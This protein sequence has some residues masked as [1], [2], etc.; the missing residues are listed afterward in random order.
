MRYNIA[1]RV[2]VP[3]G[4]HSYENGTGARASQEE[5]NREIVIISYRLRGRPYVRP[6]GG[7][8]EK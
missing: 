8:G 7:A 6:K 3:A 5:D 4:A 2:R 1:S